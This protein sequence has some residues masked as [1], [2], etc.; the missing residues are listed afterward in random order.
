L[1]SEHRRVRRWTRA[2][3]R[4]ASAVGGWLERIGRRASDRLLD[5][6]V[7]REA[8][9]PVDDV[10]PVR[11]VLLVRPNFRLGNALITSPLIGALRERFPGARIDYLGGEGTLAA[12]EHLALD[13]RLVVS[14]GFVL[15]PWRFLALFLRLR[16][17]GYDVAVE[18]AMGSFSG[19]LYVYLSGARFRVG[20][21]GRSDRFLNVRLPPAPVTHAYDG[22][23]AF[24]ARL[25]VACARQPV[26]VVTEDEAAAARRLLAALGLADGALVEPYLALFVGGHG[27]KRW[28]QA[29][30]VELATRLDAAGARV[31]VFTGPDEAGAL[32]ELRA[33]L[34]GV[35]HVL[36]PQPLR[37]FA[38]VLATSS[39][40]VT[41]DSGPMHLAA[42]LDVPCVAVLS[43]PAS[44][45]F[46]PRGPLD[47]S[48]VE[49]SVGEVEG[50]VQR[51][52]RWESLV[53]A[54]RPAAVAA[55]GR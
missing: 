7:P 8:E 20:V 31:V 50:A 1:A 35:A 23:V 17:R 29:S 15:R 38:A 32:P 45:F 37:A 30:W 16:R 42:A 26:Y 34:D 48:L 18:G 10:R 36:G 54:Q 11:S 46:P 19:G 6:V 21:A 4:I 33:L 2:L 27:R 55:G 41:P 13:E 49:P 22:P 25:G 12:V 40:A 51:H 39:L 47:V 53:E 52:P 43:N 44:T 14:R 9:V 5:L 3:R 28:P 24:A